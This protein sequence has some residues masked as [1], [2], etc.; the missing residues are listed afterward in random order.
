VDSRLIFRDKDFE[1][2]RVSPTLIRPRSAD[3]EM[4]M[5]QRNALMIF[6][7]ILVV[8]GIL[9]FAIPVLTTQ[10]TEEVARIGDLKLQA[11]HDTSYRVPPLASGAV[12]TVGL[13]LLGAG[14]YQ[15][16]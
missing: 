9:G 8:V 5:S 16:R 2:L 1:H 12:L 4:T 7:A 14:L 15:R 10:R 6:G 13:I 11:T 3:K